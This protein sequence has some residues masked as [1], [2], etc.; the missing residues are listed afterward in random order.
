[1]RAVTKVARQCANRDFR[2]VGPIGP[3]EASNA[4]PAVPA[5][6]CRRGAPGTWRWYLL[7]GES[8]THAGGLLWRFPA[9]QL[10]QQYSLAKGIT[11]DNHLPV[12]LKLNFGFKIADDGETATWWEARRRGATERKPEPAFA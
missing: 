7:G 6:S 10:S 1:M 12:F 5:R 2:C 4:C 9:L 11:H 8:E 3:T